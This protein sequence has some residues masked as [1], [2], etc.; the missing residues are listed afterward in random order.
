MRTSLLHSSFALGTLLV[1]GLMG[2]PPA[3]ADTLPEPAREGV[4]HYNE[5]NFSKA[6]EKF[7][8]AEAE[9]PDNPTV[10]Y[11]AGNTHYRLG[12][13][14]AAIED[15]NKVLSGNAPPELR[16]KTHYN[17]GNAWYRL[18][19]LDRAMESYKKALEL[20]PKDEDSKFNYEYAKQQWEQAIASGQI[21]PRNLDTLKPK[22]SATGKAPPPEESESAQNEAANHPDTS[23]QN[24]QPPE[25]D[26]SNNESKELAEQKPPAASSP[27]KRNM[28][29]LLKEAVPMSKEEA[30]RLLGSLNEDLKKFKRRQMQG[31]MQDLFKEQRKDW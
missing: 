4:A 17:E 23:E 10:R 13:Y 24:E 3:F 5:E 1:T 14:E 31:E 19:A 18:G 25:N 29:R 16:Q 6:G 15:Y 12:R 8:E 30:E 11:N 22:P 7:Q 26:T 2:H 20:N 21:M 9:A 27:E 28:D